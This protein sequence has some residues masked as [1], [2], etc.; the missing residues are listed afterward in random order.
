MRFQLN[1]NFG[2]RLALA[3]LPVLLL[4]ACGS[5]AATP[6]VRPTT[7]PAIVPATATPQPTPVPPTTV[8]PTAQTIATATL[9]PPAAT[10]TPVP[11]T[12]PSPSFD[13]DVTRFAVRQ[14]VSG[15]ADPVF[16][17]HAGDGSQR[18]FVVEKPGTV[19]IL[20]NGE[21]LPQPLLDITDRVRS[22]GSEQGL[23]GLAFPP[24]FT[25]SGYFF[26]NYTGRDG[27][28]VVSR[29]QVGTDPNRADAASE[30]T[31][32]E[33]AQPAANHNGGMLA[34]GPD[35]YLWIGTG[36]GGAANDRFRNGQNPGTLL[37]KMLRLDVTSD[38]AQPYVVPADNPWIT[39]DWN[40]QDVRDEVWAVGL[41][42]P[43]RYSFDRLTGDLWVADVGQNT[44]EEINHVPA[45]QKGYP[46]GGLN[47]GWPIMEGT[48]CFPDSA[49]CDPA[50][51]V[52]PVADYTHAEG[53][54]SVTGGYVYRGAQFPALDGVYFFGDYCSGYI[55]TLHANEDG[56]W[57]QDRVLQS[58]LAI[59]SFGEDEAG[60]LYVTD[61]GGGLYRLVVE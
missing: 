23:L 24:N 39:D 42:N 12:A 48:R 25:G 33:I 55:W 60:E 61:L 31:V 56:A 7:T 22:S 57:R 11:T 49:G 20:A 32:L 15:L 21:L 4:T 10:E 52:I 47:F 19:R 34:F 50:G 26:V 30:F 8:A 13:P 53:G 37:G 43:W 3:L 16:V 44:Y 29:F 38:P 41:R 51:L 9:V 17:T 58:G 28:T 14:L 5:Q 6:T 40:G 27:R 36:D 45:E 59:S 2:R 18:L 46:N 1:R 54:C 35:G